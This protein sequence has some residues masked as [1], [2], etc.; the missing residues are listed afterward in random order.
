M[1][2]FVVSCLLNAT[3]RGDI[4]PQCPARIP[5]RTNVTAILRLCWWDC[6]H[7]FKRNSKSRP[8][9]PAEHRTCRKTSGGLERHSLTGHFET[10]PLTHGVRAEARLGEPSV[11]LHGGISQTPPRSL[12]PQ[13]SFPTHT[14]ASVVASQRTTRRSCCDTSDI[15]NVAVSMYASSV[16]HFGVPRLRMQLT[17][18]T[19]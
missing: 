11:L 7:N 17:Q 3:E 19:M 1:L 12:V 9:S 10:A 14:I 6:K 13:C 15:R 2:S 16:E 5:T 8:R 18:S 4:R